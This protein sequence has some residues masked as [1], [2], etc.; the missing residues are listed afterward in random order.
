MNFDF[1][2][3]LVYMS[4]VSFALAFVCY[5]FIVRLLGKEGTASKVAQVVLIPLIIVAFDVCFLC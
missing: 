2:F 5:Y 3:F 1:F 4:I